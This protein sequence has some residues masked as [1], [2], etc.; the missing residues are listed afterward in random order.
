[1]RVTLRNPKQGVSDKEIAA[2]EARLGARLP[3]DYKAFLGIHNGSV[4]ETNVFKVN[5]VRDSGVNQFIPFKDL[6]RQRALVADAPAGKTL[7]IA[8][9]EGG[10]L[11]C[12]DLRNGDAILFWDHEDPEHP[13][14]LARGFDRFVELLHPF[15][16]LSM[17]LKPGRVRRP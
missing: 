16:V 11:V 2:L 7:P 9:A 13:T 3:E 1:M 10:N 12:L 15:D 4:P 17:K 6:L 14:L 5:A 8:W